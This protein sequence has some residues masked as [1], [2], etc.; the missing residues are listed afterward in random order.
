ME[1][2]VTRTKVTP[3]R[4]RIV[5][6]RAGYRCQKCGLQFD[7]P[8]GYTGQYALTRL[9]GRLAKRSTFRELEYILELDHVIP[10]T[11]GGSSDLSNMQAL[12]T[13]CNARKWVHG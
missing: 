3:R 11:K 2:R 6:E 8:P 1:I 4:R 10:V 13:G 12:C 7:C 5:Y 9:M